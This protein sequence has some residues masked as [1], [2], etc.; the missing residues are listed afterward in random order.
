MIQSVYIKNYGA[1]APAAGGWNRP[2]EWLPIPSIGAEEV[3]CYILVAVF[4]N[5]PNVVAF[6]AQVSGGVAID[7]GDGSTY[8]GSNANHEHAYDYND[9][10]PSTEY[11]G[12]RQALIKVNGIN[13]SNQWLL[14]DFYA[15]SVNYPSVNSRNFL[16]VV[17]GMRS[18]VGVG[19]NHQ[20]GL[21]VITYPMLQRIK[22]AN[23]F[24]YNGIGYWLQGLTRI[25]KL[26]IPAGETVYLARECF[27]NCGLKQLPSGV[28]FVVNQ[29]Y[30]TFINSLLEEIEVT[31]NSGYVEQYVMFQGTVARRIVVHNID[32]SET[33]SFGTLT[34]PTIQHLELHGF[35]RGHSLNGNSMYGVDTW[36]AWVDS[37]GNAADALQNITISTAQYNSFGGS[38]SYV[39][40]EVFAKGYT[41]IVV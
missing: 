23:N 6:N 4:P 27:S 26:D 11:L 16:D 5:Q 38:G 31:F 28:T 2:T 39:D 22:Y 32:A 1:S 34:S 21:G 29:A 14:L 20:F 9:L 7:W 10:D 17:I 15:P 41:L 18:D 40:D 19:S 36:T 3:V 24:S 35:T 13:P 12:Y 37:I 8:S 30:L 33:Q 25:E